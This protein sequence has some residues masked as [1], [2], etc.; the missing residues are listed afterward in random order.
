MFQD[1]LFVIFFFITHKQVYAA[2]HF[3]GGSQVMKAIIGLFALVNT[4]FELFYLVFFAIKV[5]V[6][7]AIILA[8]VAL[9]VTLILNRAIARRT[10]RKMQKAGWDINGEYF[11]F[12]Y[13]HKCDV[14]ATLIADIGLI[15]NIA[16]IIAFF[17]L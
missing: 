10:I 8:I 9:V 16:I 6:I 13:N 4:G 3:T 2:S 5:S 11:L 15:I 17:L 7:H 14:A 1:F 12:S